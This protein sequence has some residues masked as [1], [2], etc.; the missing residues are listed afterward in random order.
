[1]LLHIPQVLTPTEVADIRQALALE[2]WVDG[3]LSTGP[4]AARVK[5]N[6]QLDP[7][8]PAFAPLSQRI[9]QAL[10]RHPMF[11]SAVLPHTMLPPMFNRYECGGHYGNH[12]DNTIQTHRVNA[13]K[14][15]TDVSTTVF[16]SSPD[17][18]EGG[19]L[20]A[21]DSYGTH[22]IKLDAGDAIVYPSTSLH[23]VEPVTRGMRVASFL[24]AQSLV[25]DAWRRAMLF[26][27]DMTILKLRHQ[28]GDAAEVVALTGHYHKL[29]QQWAET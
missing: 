6:Q 19:E 9:A 21:E 17:E 26:D 15:R 13:Q 22:E 4:Q 28:L 27:L 12:I 8:S 3:L 25:R 10:N 5:R 16:L 14:V 7:A 18:Y 24:W 11:V 1:M 2:G 23:R 20:I 29:L